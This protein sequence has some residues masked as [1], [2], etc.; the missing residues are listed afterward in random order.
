MTDTDDTDIPPTGVTHWH[1]DLAGRCDAFPT[2]FEALARA[3]VVLADEARELETDDFL[4]RYHD[5]YYRAACE[6]IIRARTLHR[7]AEHARVAAEQYRLPVK[8]RALKIQD[9]GDLLDY[10][11][12]V[13]EMVNANQIGQ[14]R[15]VWECPMDEC[16]PA[17]TDE[18]ADK[19]DA[20]R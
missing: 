7:V 10:A 11:R 18:S 17:A 4:Q 6:A 1:V 3:S 9:A 14:R 5:K 20:Q 13:V 19:K 12:T 2:I 8:D 16:A 15:A